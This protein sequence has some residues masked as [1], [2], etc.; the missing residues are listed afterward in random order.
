MQFSRTYFVVTAVCAFVAATLIV[1]GLLLQFGVPQPTNVDETAALANNPLHKTSLWI[2]IAIV[3]FML[4]TLWG[5]A[6]MKLRAAAGAAT[7]GFVFFLPDFLATFLY[8]SL[9]LFTAN[10]IWLRLQT[11]T[12]RTQRELLLERIG[13]LNDIYQALFFLILMGATVGALLYGDRLVARSRVGA[14]GEHRLPDRGRDQPD[15]LRGVL[16]IHPIPV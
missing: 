16:R 9:Q 7:A 4:A 12:E 3:F 5:V 2:N 14:V 10:P 6:V 8:N 1:T 11:V 15:S 13:F